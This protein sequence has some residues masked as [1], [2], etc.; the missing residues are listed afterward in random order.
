MDKN[1]PKEL[2][3]QQ[4]DCNRG[5]PPPQPPSLPGAAFHPSS[6]PPS[7]LPSGIYMATPISPTSTSSTSSSLV[8]SSTSIPPALSKTEEKTR[9]KTLKDQYKAVKKEIKMRE[10]EA[11]RQADEFKKELKHQTTQLKRELS[12]QARQTVKAELTLLNKGIRDIHLNES[13]SIGSSTRA[14]TTPS[15]PVLPQQTMVYPPASNSPTLI[16]TSSTAMALP[17]TRPVHQSLAEQ[18]ALREQAKQER[19]IAREVYKHQKRQA[20]QEHRDQRRLEREI[21]GEHGPVHDQS[22]QDLAPRVVDTMQVSPRDNAGHPLPGINAFPTDSVPLLQQ[23][24]YSP[25]HYQHAPVSLPQ[26]RQSIWPTQ[27]FQKSGTEKE[28]GAQ[29]PLIV[30]AVLGL[31][32]S[33]GSPSTSA[34]ISAPSAPTL[35]ALIASYPEQH[36]SEIFHEIPPPPYEDRVIVP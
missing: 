1:R 6:P 11:S 36:E 15:A 30:F 35:D 16:T 8:I 7:N 5:Y 29:D 34:A 3:I 14:R 23:P 4:L 17:D 31:S 32:S 25:S 20:R 18:I 21:R 33:P 26:Q 2:P 10:K 9:K 28:I 13:A 12:Q 22:S 19:R 24:V 27:T